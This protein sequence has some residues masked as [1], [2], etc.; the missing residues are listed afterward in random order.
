MNHLVMS[1]NPRVR[2][3]IWSWFNKAACLKSVSDGWYG[4]TMFGTI[5]K[6]VW[7]HTDAKIRGVTNVRTP[8]FACLK[9]LVNATH[10]YLPNTY[11]RSQIRLILIKKYSTTHKNVI[12]KLHK[13]DFF[14]K[15]YLVNISLI[16]LKS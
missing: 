2:E 3:H 15:E 16:G 6:M 8:F 13:E 5:L 1:S 14:H 9:K 4:T 11:T 12:V 7:Y 10:R